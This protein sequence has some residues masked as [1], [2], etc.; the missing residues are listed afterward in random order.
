MILDLQTSVK[1]DWRQLKTSTLA[2]FEATLRLVDDVKTSTT[3]HNLAI[4]VADP[5]RLD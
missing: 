5:Q 1:A 2:G 3:P 4:P